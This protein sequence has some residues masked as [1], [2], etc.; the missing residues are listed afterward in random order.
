[1]NSKNILIIAATDLSDDNSASLCHSAYIR[2]FVALGHKV[3]VLTVTPTSLKYEHEIDG[4]EYIYISDENAL[5]RKIR[6]QRKASDAKNT[7][8][9]KN[10]YKGVPVI[11]KLF[12]RV[13]KAVYKVL[14]YFFGATATWNRCVRKLSFDEHFDLSISLSSPPESHNVAG[15]LI[16]K[17][18]IDTAEWYQLW[19]DPWSTDLYENSTSVFKKEKKLLDI[20]SKIL[21]V[22]P[23]TLARQQKLFPRNASKMDWLPLP[24]YFSEEVKNSVPNGSFSFGYFGQYF[25][26]VRNLQPTYEALNKLKHRFVICGEPHELFTPTE[27]IEIHAR[28][29]PNELKEFEERT[30]VLVFVANLGGGQIPG[31]IYQYSSTNKWILFVLDGNEDEKKV[32]VDYFGKFERYVFCDNNIESIFESVQNIVSGQINDIK[33][34]RVEYFNASNIAE[35]ILKKCNM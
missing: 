8:G 4:A 34:T 14:L 21:Y 2:G 20:A 25:P 19:E 23:L 10:G 31:K 28:V 35:E 3:K 1:M 9:Q 22:S 27:T 13:K 26:H 32:L 30:N 6:A 29:T 17:G 24:T 15:K 18:K 16:K 5:I 12:N 11:K 33:N 7:D